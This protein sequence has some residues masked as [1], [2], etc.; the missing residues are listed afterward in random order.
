[1]SEANRASLLPPS[2][3]GSLPCRSNRCRR[4]GPCPLR[5]PYGWHH[6]GTLATTR[7]F[8][9]LPTLMRATSW[10]LAA[11]MTDTSSPSTLLMQQYLPSGLNVSQAGPFPV[12]TLLTIFWLAVS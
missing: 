10:R 7:R 4:H 1:P 3:R 8:G 12:P 6:L 5:R 11:S 2:A 9:I